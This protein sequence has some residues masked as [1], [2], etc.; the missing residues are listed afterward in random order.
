MLTL[1]VYTSKQPRRW[2]KFILFSLA[3]LLE[4]GEKL[5][6]ASLYLGSLFFK[7]DECVKNIFPL[8]RYHVVTMLPP[9]FYKFSLEVI[10]NT[11][12]KAHSI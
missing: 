6:L 11:F 10:W 12:T 4:K 2:P 9:P 3:I 7:L 1:V 5:A 8:L